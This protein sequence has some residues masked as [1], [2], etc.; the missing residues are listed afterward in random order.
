MIRAATS[1]DAAP[2][3]AIYNHYVSTTAISFEEEPITTNEMASRMPAVLQSSMPWLVA[4]RD[5]QVLGYAY[6]ARWRERR[7]YRFSVETTVYIAPDSGG[8]GVGTAL[9]ARL[10]ELLRGAGYHAAM[11]VIALP[12]APSIALHEKFGMRKVAHFRE[13]GYKFGRWHD[14]GNWQVVW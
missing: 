5:G 7:A 14:V 2:V 11:G 3:V 4:E 6:A 9:Y 12:N 1:A 10:F 13:V 8:Q